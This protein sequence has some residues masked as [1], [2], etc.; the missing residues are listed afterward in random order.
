M[1][2][3]ILG[4]VFILSAWNGWA[5][6]DT[7]TGETKKIKTLSEQTER[8]HLQK[9]MLKRKKLSHFRGNW[10]GLYLGFMDFGNTDYTEY[11]GNDFLN[12]DM[13][14]SVVVQWNVESF[15]LPLYRNFG[16]VSGVGLEYQRMRFNR[17]ITLRK[18]ERGDLQPLVLSDIGIER[19]KRSSFK[20]LYLTLPLLVEY[21]FN[22]KERRPL[23]VS[24]GIVGGLRLHSKTKVVYKSEAGNKRK[25]KESGSYNMLPV[26]A[27]A[28]VRLGL[29]GVNVWG[30][31]SLTPLFD[32]GCA[33]KVHPYAIGFGFT[34]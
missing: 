32:T 25:R 1:K 33:P 29:L 10:E 19:V 7:I 26:K 12:L 9:T 23:Y 5:Q 31:Y 4:M 22:P 13:A 18:D 34:F 27:D 2:V 11:G 6:Q 15:A 17:D 30:S 8:S 24:V 16:I 21:Q 20:I 3:I 28:M 14:G